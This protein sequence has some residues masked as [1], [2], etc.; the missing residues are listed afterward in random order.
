[1]LG[2]VTIEPL[3]KRRPV[4]PMLN[5]GGSHVPRHRIKYDATNPAFPNQTGKLLEGCMEGRAEGE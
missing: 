5:N 4:I 3:I 2:E 1:M